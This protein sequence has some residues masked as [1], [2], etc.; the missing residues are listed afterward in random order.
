MRKTILVATIALSTAVGAAGGMIIADAG[1]QPAPPPA[2][3]DDAAPPPPPGHGWM[4]GWMHH[5]GPDGGPGRDRGMHLMRTFGLMYHPEDK[6]LS[7]ADAQK[8]AEAFLLWNGNHTWKV[9]N[10]AEGP[11]NK[12]AFALAT[13]EGSVV[14]RFTMDRKTGRVER[15]G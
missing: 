11:D 2:A 12:V 7:T 13:Q 4:Q 8:I 15:T 1:A 6:Q 10:V 5:R 9:T 3:L 14:A